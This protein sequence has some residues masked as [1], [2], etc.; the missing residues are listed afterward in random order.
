M[1]LG[2]VELGVSEELLGIA[3]VS[4]APQQVDGNRVAEDVGVQ[5][6][7]SDDPLPAQLLEEAIDRRPLP[8]APAGCSRAQEAC[9]RRIRRLPR[10][11]NRN[12]RPGMPMSAFTNPSTG[13]AYRLVHTDGGWRITK[14]RDDNGQ[15]RLV[16]LRGQTGTGAIDTATVAKLVAGE[17]GA[18][19]H[20]DPLATFAAVVLL[21]IE[22]T[23]EVVIALAH[24][25]QQVYETGCP[26]FRP[27][28]ATLRQQRNRALA[29]ARDECRKMAQ[30]WQGS[31]LIPGRELSEWLRAAMEDENAS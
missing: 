5:R 12:G 10:P 30:A 16:H 21:D 14:S 28:S 26:G 29:Q 24:Q 6:P 9:H 2:R 19:G 23:G 20:A 15:L 13:T 11:A 3:D 17:G 31:G 8:V 4:P 7:A 25:A 18:T 22:Q 1:D 27:R